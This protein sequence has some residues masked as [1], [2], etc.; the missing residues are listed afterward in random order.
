MEPSELNLL[1]PEQVEAIREKALTDV[2]SLLDSVI[3]MTVNAVN[4]TLAMGGG[5][6]VPN[7]SELDEELIIEIVHCLAAGR[8]GK[9]HMTMYGEEEAVAQIAQY[10]KEKRDADQQ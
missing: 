10:M 8:A 1:P 5:P 9:L 4:R 7:H 3:E 2:R 6:V